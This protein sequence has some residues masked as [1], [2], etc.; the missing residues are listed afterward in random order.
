MKRNFERWAGR[1]L[2]VALMGAVIAPRAGQAAPEEAS[3]EASAWRGRT[4][5]RPQPSYW[6][7]M[8][9]TTLFLGAGTAWYWANRDENSRD[10]DYDSLSG[11][12]EDGH[13]RFDNN[14]YTINNLVH[15]LDGGAYYLFARANGLPVHEA[16]AMSAMASTFWEYVLEYRERVSIN[17][18]VLTPGGG[19]VLG[20]ATFQLADY[21]S[22]APDRGTWAH[23]LAAWTL[24]F[25][26][27][28]H[29]AL[30]GRRPP[31]GPVDNLG[32]SSR[33]R[34]DFRVAYES[35]RPN[36]GPPSHGVNVHIRLDSLRGHDRPGNFRLFFADGN[37]VELGVRAGFNDN[38]ATEV[39]VRSDI[40]VLGYYSQSFDRLG[41]GASAAARL[42]LGF[43]HVQRWHPEPSDRISTLHLP[44]PSLELRGRNGNLQ[45]R[46]QVDLSP[47]FAA[48]DGIAFPLW[49]ALNPGETTKSVTEEFYYY[50]G[51]GGSARF[52]ASGSW[53]G[54]ELGGRV[55]YSHYDSI[56]GLD[57]EQESITND[58]NL[59][60]DLYEWGGWLGWADRE[61]LTHVRVGLEG[62]RRTGTAGDVAVRQ[63]R[64]RVALQVGFAL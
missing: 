7:A 10:W 41:D 42:G 23:E 19:M 15:P 53:H 48:L 2:I 1:L 17:D 34:H 57:R 30:D 13:I 58:L 14:H 60:D 61:A 38:G 35:L 64:R 29:D 31:D 9:E 46:L 56:D 47:D 20:E 49:K 45:G 25:P 18:M 8:G 50:Y 6:R 52:E 40:G 63:N 21:L 22:S 11:R 55:R 32:F 54:L 3:G 4:P 62:I 28:V 33:R 44:G 27:R 43:E 59:G 37:H 16:F 5:P 12:F 26:V 36:R 24:G 39:D 51:F